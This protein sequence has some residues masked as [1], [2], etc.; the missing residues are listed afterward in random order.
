MGAGA[1][2]V[3]VGVLLDAG[4]R[5]LV[6]RRHEHLHQGG[7]WEFPGGKIHPGESVFEALVR[8]FAEELGLHVEA[9]EP[10]LALGHDYADRRVLLEVWRITR[11]TGEARGL[12]GQPVEWRPVR[13]L[14]PV[15]FPAANGPI[16]AALHALAMAPEP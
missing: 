5:V 2:R 12:E 6:S 9:A 13:A 3:A 15:D 8:E 1:L 11:C 16:V 14:D 10:M 7:L 4:G